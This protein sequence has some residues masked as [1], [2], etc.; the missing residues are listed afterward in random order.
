MYQSHSG[1]VETNRLFDYLSRAADDAQAQ[2]PSAEMVFLG[3]FNCHHDSWLGSPITNHAG[4]AAHAFALTQSLTQLV[5]QPT[6]ILDVSGQAPSLLDLLLTTYPAGYQVLIQGPLGYSDH[7]LVS[8]T[9]PGTIPPQPAAAKRQV[10]H[11]SSADWDGMRNYFAS[12]PW[13]C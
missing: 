13:D 2:Y 3:D 5:N 6:S 12:V 9:V 1:D 10:W 11:Y 8:S 4:S 7:C